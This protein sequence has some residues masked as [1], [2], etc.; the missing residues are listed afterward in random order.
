MALPPILSSDFK[1]WVN[2]SQ[3]IY[4]TDL[5]IYIDEFYPEYVKQILGSFACNWLENNAITQ[6]YTDIFDGV[7]YF[8]ISCDKWLKTEGLTKAI[9]RLIYF[10]WIQ[11]N[12]IN[13][14]N[15]I[16]NVIN[17]NE[18]STPVTA[19]E[20][21][22]IAKSRFNKAS[23]YVKELC[24]FV[25]NYKNFKTDITSSVDN[26][27]TYTINTA[28]TLYL[29]NGDTVSINSTDYVVSSI[30][31]DTS[32]DITEATAGIDFSAFQ[33]IQNPYEDTI[34]TE[35]GHII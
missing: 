6:K 25:E 3:K 9:I 35:L 12:F 28:S 22:G 11:D 33:W 2:L 17:K 34:V 14:G 20:N 30:V 18:N 10:E 32:F 8:D 23:D 7:F 19:L 21:S 5:Q 4:D 31:A 24:L 29:E 27:G 16:G 15:G 13:T 26:T 1:G